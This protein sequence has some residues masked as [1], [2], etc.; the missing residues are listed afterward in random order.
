MVYAESAKVQD[1]FLVERVVIAEYL[2]QLPDD[3]KKYVLVDFDSIDS[4]FVETATIQFI[5]S[6][7]PNIQYITLDDLLM[8]PPDAKEKYVIIPVISSPGLHA[9]LT[10]LIQVELKEEEINGITVISHGVG[11]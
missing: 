11:E 10:D 6:R 1:A 3:V 4:A 8:K 5:T 2:N 7:D 9:E